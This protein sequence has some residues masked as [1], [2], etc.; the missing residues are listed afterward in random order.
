MD[1]HAVD[2]SREP[3]E[4]LATAAA[5]PNAERMAARLTQDARQPAEMLHRI[6]KDGEVHA[7]L[8]H[9]VVVHQELL[10]ERHQRV[11][12]GNLAVQPRAGVVQLVAVVVPKEEGAEVRRGEGAPLVFAGQQ[13][14]KQRVK[15]NFEGAGQR[16]PEKIQEPPL[17]RLIHQ[18]VVKDSQHLVDPGAQV[19]VAR[20]VGAAQL[21][22]RELREAR[23]HARHVTQV[24]QV[25]DLGGRRQQRILHRL[26]H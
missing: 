1:G 25:E 5:K 23:H 19:A 3:A 20:I 2:E 21:A 7:L 9:A 12:F 15:L 11:R 8:A 18:A 26:V 4:A 17:V 24:E 6:Q 10:H 14:R 22:G 16:L 13:P